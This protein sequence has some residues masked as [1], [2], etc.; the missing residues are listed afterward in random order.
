MVNLIIILVIAGILFLAGLYI[1]KEKKRGKSC[2]GCPYSGSCSG[3]CST[4]ADS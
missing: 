2:I 4:N 1:Y 3:K